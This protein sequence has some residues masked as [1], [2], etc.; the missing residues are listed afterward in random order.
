MNY[1]K[2]QSSSNSTLTKINAYFF[3]I[4]L[5]LIH[6][7]VN[8]EVSKVSVEGNYRIDQGSILNVVQT[9]V[10]DA[11]DADHLREDMK[12]IYKLGFFD[13]VE[14]D[15]TQ[16]G[17]S[18]FITFKV[19]ERPAI[20]KISFEGNEAIS[21]STLKEKLNLDERKFL[22]KKKLATSI[23]ELIAYYQGEGYYGTD[24]SYS[25]E[26]LKE[27]EVNLTVKVDEGTKKLIRK[28]RFAGVS[29]VS[30]S[31]LESLVKTS[32]Y[33]WLTSW[34]TGSG[35]VKKEYLENDSKLIQHHYLTKGYAEVKVGTPEVNSIEKGL[36]VVF[37]IEEGPQYKFGKIDAVGT[38]LNENK[39]QTLENIK[40]SQGEV[41]NVDYLREDVFS[42]T[43]KFTDVGYAFANVDPLTK[44]NRE[45]KTVDL[46]FSV[47]KGD[48]IKINRINIVGND[49]TQDNVIRRNLKISEQELFSSSKIK[50]SQ[51]L[52]KRQG[53]F[54]EVTI[55][56]EKTEKPG[57]VDLSVGVKEAMT[58][59][60]S[61]GAGVSSGDGFIVTSKISENNLFGSG[62]SLSLDIN[63]GQLRQNYIASFVNPRVD[64]SYLS[65][66]ADLAVTQRN[67]EDF[68]R[69]QNGGSINFG[70]PLFFLGDKLADDIRASL[71]YELMQNE[72]SDIDEDVAPLV[73]AQ[74][75]KGISSALVPSLTR[76]TI[77]NPLDPSRGSKQF[78]RFDYAGVGGD[79]KYWM[80]QFN[81]Y[82]YYPMVETSFGSFVFAQ[83]TKVGWGEPITGDVFPLFQR[84]FPGGIN[85]IRGY[86]ARQVGP[87]DDKGNY[88]GGSKQLIM[89]FETI[90]PLV[91]SIGLN[92]VAFYDAGNAYDDNQNINFSDIRQ[93]VGWGFR[94][95][96]P[97]APIRVEIG[98]PMDKQ[99][100]DKS[101]VV[102]FSF[103]A[104]L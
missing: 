9:K 6:G 19:H 58:G 97:L 27:G 1:F 15:R 42:I 92:G 46:N 4:S 26:E 52:I 83:R 43:D 96:S 89:N 54:E 41:F 12:A 44:I 73:R 53:F 59:Q 77:D 66:G 103:G 38:L 35:V 82:W 23:K 86:N 65:F 93:A 10:G 74:E 87:K 37:N 69:R 60:F 56:P 24:I 30:S 95:R 84:F 72:I 75:G 104:P 64:D 13:K 21:S 3:V 91:P 17:D 22:D 14:I 55:S 29:N 49:K 11:Y 47:D 88:Y 16:Q 2:S 101:M 76:S 31:D 25:T 90:F 102:N 39:K 61:A 34:A 32:P 71:G 51:E 20:K 40:S 8:A 70:Y 57:E 33:F 81:N 62:N 98:Y 99:P 79:Q 18:D 100:G 78:M 94:W 45:T 28:I 67:F 80:G 5:A 50:R 48:K 68:M 36:E 7:V 85:S 63:S